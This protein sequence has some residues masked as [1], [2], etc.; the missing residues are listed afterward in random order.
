MKTINL[1]LEVI[2]T[3]E[4]VIE[5]LTKALQTEDFG[6]LTRIDLHLKIKEKLG[7]DILP[8][9]ILGTCNPELAFQAYTA[10]SDV[11]SLLPCNAVIRKLTSGRFSVELAK[12]TALMA[13]LGDENLIHL[14][15]TADHKLERVLGVLRQ[16][17]D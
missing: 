13:M 11:A 16:T 2:G 6:V 1:K 8:V 3:I 17:M 12:P 4:Q 15:Q 9:V 14:A 10:H 5:N 7:K